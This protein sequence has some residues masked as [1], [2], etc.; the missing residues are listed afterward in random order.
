MEVLNELGCQH[1]ASWIDGVAS[2][3][4]W[5]GS[6]AEPPERPM[7]IAAPTLDEHLFLVG[8]PPMSEF[9]LYMKSTV[10]AADAADERD[11]ARLWR[12]AHAHVRLLCEREAGSAEIATLNPLPASIMALAEEE[13]RSPML[14]RSVPAVPWQWSFVEL[15]RLVVYQKFVNLAYA[16]ELAQRLS[17]NPTDAELFQFALGKDQRKTPVHLAELAD[18]SFVFSSASTDLR[19][20]DL[21]AL[22]PATVQGFVA[23]G[24]AAAVIGVFV[25]LGVN[26]LIALRI[27]D[28]LVLANG[29]HRAY[30]LRSRGITHAPFLILDVTR[31]EDFELAAMAELK[32]NASRYLTAPRPPLFKDYF[33]PMLAHRV[34]VPRRKL[35][36]KV[37]CKF[38]FARVPAD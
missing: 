8:R 15:D 1:D 34:R 26:L 10:C 4:A 23:S 22:D 33:D 19:C 6:I 2:A 38:Q 16:R 5:W 30:A 37:E 12:A 35:T 31:E 20:L 25:G 3:G 18:N 27:R 21:V 13:L 29:T 9:I 24:H 17:A 28:R 14:L 36:V 32:Q 11:A 7:S